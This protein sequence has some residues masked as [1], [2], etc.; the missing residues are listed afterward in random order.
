MV[1]LE[2]LIKFIDFTHQLQQVQRVVLIKN[3]DVCEND[4][5][6]MY[7]L[8]MV[9]WYLAEEQKLS[10]D[11]NKIIAYALVHDVVEGYAGD[12]FFYHRTAAETIDKAKREAD[13][14]EKLKIEF[15]ESFFVK[16]I[17][18]PICL[19]VWL[20]IFSIPKIGFMNATVANIL[21]LGIYYG[22]CKIKN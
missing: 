16:L 19:S 7:Q 15:P 14:I 9:A 8:A 12:T 10:L 22:I 17:T 20:S 18:C 4:Q 5:E 6:H 3:K 21:S 1:S 11:K 2:P 13:A